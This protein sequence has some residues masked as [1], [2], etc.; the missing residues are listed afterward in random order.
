MASQHDTV[1]ISLNV[2]LDALDAPTVLVDHDYRIHTANRAYCEAY[3][4]A[5]D[6]VVGRTCHEVSHG[7]PEPCHR[8]GECCP[9]R[10]VFESGASCDV[11][12]TH[13]RADGTLEAV[14]IRA[15]LVRDHAGQPYLMES[16]Q[17][18]PLTLPAGDSD[19]HRLNRIEAEVIRDLLQQRYNR[20]EIAEKLGISE[21]TL[22]R[23]LNKY[24]LIEPEPAEVG[25]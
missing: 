18:Q 23:K 2:L 7:S 17:Q 14:S 24:A 9:H 8:H 15:H 16:V 20:R 25:R 11:A 21:R 12:H 4:V 3:G 6:E 5:P 1:T 19:V 22:Y 10:Q 13:R